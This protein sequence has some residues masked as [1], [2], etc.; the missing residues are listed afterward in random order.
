MGAARC[1]SRRQGCLRTSLSLKISFAYTMTVAG[2]TVCTATST[3][4]FLEQ[5]RPVSLEKRF[6]EL[7]AM[8]QNL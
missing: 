1:V 7:Y 2:R 6:P 8:I 5:G 3:H 4:C